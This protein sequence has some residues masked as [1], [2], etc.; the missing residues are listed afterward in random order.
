MSYEEQPDILKKVSSFRHR[1]N[2]AVST[3]IADMMPKEDEEDEE[4]EE[5]GLC[6]C[7][8][9]KKSR[10]DDDKM[11]GEEKKKKKEKKPPATQ[12][13]PQL[14]NASN[15]GVNMMKKLFFPALPHLL[16]DLWVY[17]EF[18]I[19]MFAFV[20]GVLSLDLTEGS[21]IFNIVY[22]ILTIISIVLAVIDCFVYFIQMGSCAECLKIARVKLKKRGEEAELEL[23]DIE[24]QENDGCCRMNKQKKEKFNIYF[25]IVRNIVSEVILYPLLICD[26]FDFIVGGVFRNIDAND[27][28]DFSLFVVGSFYLIL[29][30]YIMRMFIIVGSVFESESHTDNAKWVRITSK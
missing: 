7:F 16:Q 1:A 8:K 10:D 20:L 3:A 22:L 18:G 15:Q 26:L 24:K 12:L 5:G 23:L 27:Q 4:E 25:E 29:S 2:K 17:L 14:K 28:L 11:L 13:S 30:V 21:K 6:D 9:K 19:S